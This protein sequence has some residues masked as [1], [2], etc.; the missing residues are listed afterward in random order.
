MRSLIEIKRVVIPIEHGFP[1]FIQFLKQG[2][3]Y[4]IQYIE[5]YEYV[6]IVRKSFYIQL[7]YDL[8][9]QHAFVCD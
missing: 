4:F 8:P 7:F 1:C 3:L 9:V 2:M 5:T 6:F